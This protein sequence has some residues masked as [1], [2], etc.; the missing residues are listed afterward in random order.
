M[1]NKEV[2]FAEIL[3]NSNKKIGIARLNQPMTLNALSLSILEKL[4]KQLDDWQK[5]ADIVAVWLESTE[6]KYFC[7]GGNLLDVYMGRK[8][9]SDDSEYSK[10]ATKYF[11][12]EYEL[13]YIIHTYNKPFFAFGSGLV[14]GGG[15]GLFQGAKYRLVTDNSSL[16]MPE[17]KIGLFPDVGATWF[18][19]KLP[20]YMTLFLSLTGISINA[21]DA[22]LLG[23]ADYYLPATEHA[24]LFKLLV[25]LNWSKEIEAEAKIQ[26]FFENFTLDLGS[27]IMPVIEDI[28][29]MCTDFS[30]AKIVNNLKSYAGENKF[31]QIA[32]KL[33]KYASPSSLKLTAEM[34]RNMRNKTLE[35]SLQLDFVVTSA[36]ALKGEFLEGIRALLI[37][38]D[39]KPNWRFKQVED[40][41]LEWLQDFFTLPAD[42]QPLNLDKE[43]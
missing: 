5:D 24:K 14:L 40:V 29:A 36:S 15:M 8:Q 13:D 16:A 12:A 23:L 1:Q 33:V 38:K 37:D 43:S 17:T 25:R 27:Q 35:D 26:D 41:T 11:R 30:D 2:I 34:M 32:T 6:A 3:T 21:K 42:Y 20:L 18:Y 31:L 22:L 9:I 28:Q 4:T 10:I 39:K 19:N 7:A